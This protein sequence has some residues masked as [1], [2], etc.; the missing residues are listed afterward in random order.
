VDHLLQMVQLAVPQQVVQVV[1]LVVVVEL[2]VV[3]VAAV[4]VVDIP[5]AAVVHKAVAQLQVVE[6]HMWLL[7]QPI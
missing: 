5:V 7:G 1:V 3:L 2:M 4:V 6:D